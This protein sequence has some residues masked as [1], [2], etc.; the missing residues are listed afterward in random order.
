MQPKYL[1]LSEILSRRIEAG[2]WT[3][4]DRLPSEVLLAKEYGVAY[5]TVRSAVTALVE[6]GRL[7]RIRG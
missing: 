2:E 1:Q 3:V 7:R 5:M 6:S 4:G